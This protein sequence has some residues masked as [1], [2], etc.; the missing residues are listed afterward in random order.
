MVAIFTTFTGIF[1]H[2]Y[3]SPVYTANGTSTVL[4]FSSVSTSTTMN[5]SNK[6]TSSPDVS[7]NTKKNKAVLNSTLIST[8]QPTVPTTIENSTSSSNSISSSQGMSPTDFIQL[9]QTMEEKKKQQDPYLIQKN[10]LV[11]Y[12]YHPPLS[13]AEMA[14]LPEDIQNV[15]PMGQDE[16]MLQIQVL[17]NQILNYNYNIE[18]IY[19][20]EIN[21]YS[22]QN[23]I[24]VTHPIPTQTNCT[25]S[26][27]TVDCYTN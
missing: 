22:I 26:Y 19:Q 10:I 12:L 3:N 23:N 20:T 7:P 24:P 13:L 2:S 17:N 27:D 14:E 5:E 4:V 11:D 9:L 15:I 18:K 16:I 1:H 8:S 6:L 25:K 21:N